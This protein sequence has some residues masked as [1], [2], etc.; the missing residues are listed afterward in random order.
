MTEP[1]SA[2][3]LANERANYRY[4]LNDPT[5]PDSTSDIGATV[6]S[7]LLQMQANNGGIVL[8]PTLSL[9]QMW[10]WTTPSGINYLVDG[11]TT[12]PANTIIEGNGSLILIGYGSLTGNSL[13]EI[14]NAIGVIRIVGITFVGNSAHTGDT[15]CVLQLQSRQLVL[16]NLQFWNVQT[17]N[18]GGS[19]T[20]SSNDV[21]LRDCLFV[22]CADSTVSRSGV[23][24]LSC[25]TA[26]IEN[27]VFLDIGEFDGISGTRSAPQSWLNVQAADTIE[28]SNCNFD[29]TAT[30][31]IWIGPVTGTTVYSVHIRSNDIAMS[32]RVGGSTILIDGSVAAIDS[33]VIEDNRFLLGFAGAN[34]VVSVNNCQNVIF[35]RNHFDASNSHSVTIGANVKRLEFDQ[36]IGNVS[37]DTTSGYPTDRYLV[38]GIDVPFAVNHAGSPYTLLPSQINIRADVSGGPITLVVPATTTLDDGRVMTLEVPV[39]DAS[40]NSITLQRAGSDTIQD[41][42]NIGATLGT[43]VVYAQKGGAASWEACAAQAQWRLLSSTATTSLPFFRTNHAGSP[44]TLSLVQLNVLSDSSGGTIAY[45]LPAAP[46]DQT[47]FEVDNTTRSWST[48]PVTVTAGGS[49]HIQD[50]NNITAA[51]GTSVTLS[52]SGAYVKWEYGATEATWFVR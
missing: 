12:P 40:V 19:I 36:N 48:N 16:E 42:A 38:N 5:F 30:H 45:T 13:L 47:P 33:A 1:S 27:V 50:P 3:W 10:N 8:L 9:G 34:N 23:V 6:T 2:S 11:T 7:I 14:S 24:T 37:V 49:D 46:Q 26:R 25:S 43:S 39:G 41:P 28:I 32:N 51:P 17:G 44:Y 31:Q 21:V 4:W 35:R 52:V 22:G 15:P 29:E 18:V 20:T